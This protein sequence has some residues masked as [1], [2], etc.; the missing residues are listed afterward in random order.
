ML[1][2]LDGCKVPGASLTTD[3]LSRLVS[4]EDSGVHGKVSVEASSWTMK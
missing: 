1:R 3:M 2:G 4:R